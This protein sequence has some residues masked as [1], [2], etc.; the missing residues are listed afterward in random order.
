MRRLNWARRCP[1]RRNTGGRSRPPRRRCSARRRSARGSRGGLV[2]AIAGRQAAARSGFAT[3]LARF[4]ASFAACT[5]ASA[6]GWPSHI[7]KAV[8]PFGAGSATDV[9][10]RA[11]FDRMSAELGQTI[12]VENRT[13]AG[14]SL[15]TGVVAHAAPDGYTILAHS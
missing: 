14:G 13:G 12:V 4:A 10:P 9:V 5:Q 3:V 8:I 6:Q 7:I 11:V 2:P 1:R 15:G